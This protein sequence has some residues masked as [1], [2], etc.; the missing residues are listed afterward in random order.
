MKNKIHEKFVLKMH[1]GSTILPKKVQQ[2]SDANKYVCLFVKG[3]LKVKTFPFLEMLSKKLSKKTL[4][5]NSYARVYLWVC[6]QQFG[7]YSS[8]VLIAMSI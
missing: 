6:L 4:S 2:L 7:G 8:S 3:L 1:N 5:L